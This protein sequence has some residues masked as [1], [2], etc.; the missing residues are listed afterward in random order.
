MRPPPNTDIPCQ[1]CNGTKR[2][3]H[4]HECGACF[5]FGLSTAPWDQ[6]RNGTTITVWEGEKVPDGYTVHHS[7]HTSR[8]H[9][10]RHQDGYILLVSWPNKDYQGGPA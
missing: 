6:R 3:D 7:T 9:L 5:G 8:K 2:G 4:G 1:Q 10:G